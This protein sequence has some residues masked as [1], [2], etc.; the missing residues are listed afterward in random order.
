MSSWKRDL[1]SGL[2]VLTPILVIL[3][4]FRWLY[5][6]LAALPLTG[7]LPQPFG[8][9]VAL[10]VLVTLVLATGYL[11]RTTAGRLFENQLDAA[12]NRVPMIRILYN[13]SKLAVETALTGTKDLQRPVRLEPWP[14][15]RLTAFKTG[16]RTEDGRE[17][18]FM[19]TSPNIT[20]GFVM[21]VAPDDYEEIDETVEEALTRVLSAGFADEND[22]AASGIDVTG[23]DTVPAGVSTT[24]RSDSES[25]TTDQ[26]SENPE[27]R[28]SDQNPDSDS[29]SDSDPDPDP[30]PDRDLDPDQD[31]GPDR[32]PS[33]A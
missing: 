9:L 20:T 17:V 8:V 3:L 1:V 12:M 16:K 26:Q 7:E 27:K 22:R 4:V 24:S 30:D 11:M 15:M 31:P 33:S 32:D 13:A 10:A 6:R 2:V 18:L 28:G 25:T 14:G 23:R 19:P 29:D 21:E 5:V